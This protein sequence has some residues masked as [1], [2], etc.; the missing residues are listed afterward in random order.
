VPFGPGCYACSSEFA[1][2]AEADTIHGPAASTSGTRKCPDRALLL[3]NT[4]DQ[5]NT[6]VET[7][8]DSNKESSGEDGTPASMS[9]AQQQLGSG[10][11][12]AKRGLL[13]RALV[14]LLLWGLCVGLFG[15]LCDQFATYVDTL[16]VGF[17][18]S[19]VYLLECRKACESDWW[20]IGGTCVLWWPCKWAKSLLVLAFFLRW[21]LSRVANEFLQ[22]AV[23]LGSLEEADRNQAISSLAFFAAII[24]V[25]GAG[26]GTILYLF[27]KILV[28]LFHRALQ[29]RDSWYDWYYLRSKTPISIWPWRWAQWTRPIEVEVLES[30][31][32]HEGV[33][34][35]E[36]TERLMLEV[37]L[38]GKAS[39]L[40]VGAWPDGV[41][42]LEIITP[43][44]GDVPAT[45]TPLG[46]ATFF[47]EFGKQW[48]AITRHQMRDIAAAGEG[49]VFVVGKNG[50]IP[51]QDFPVVAGGQGSAEKHDFAIMEVTD[52]NFSAR[53]GV[54]A[55]N[56][57]KGFANR[58]VAQVYKWDGL[59]WNF[60]LAIAN[61]PAHC[62]LI[63]H[64][65]STANGTSGSPLFVM[66]RGKL[67]ILGIHIG[68]KMKPAENYA[69]NLAWFGIRRPDQWRS[70]L[71]TMKPE[72]DPRGRSEMEPEMEELLQRLIYLQE[73]YEDEL[74]E[75]TRERRLFEYEEHRDKK[76]EQQLEDA[77]YARGWGETKVPEKVFSPSPAGA[78]AVTTAVKVEVPKEKEEVSVSATMA[79]ATVKEPERP[80]KG[81]PVRPSEE[82]RKPLPEEPSE[83]EQISQENQLLRQQLKEKK[84]REENQRLKSQL[85]ESSASPKSNSAKVPVN[86][87]AV[88]KSVPSGE[89]SPM[90]EKAGAPVNTRV[91]SSKK[92]KQKM[93]KPTAS[94][95]NGDGQFVELQLN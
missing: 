1:V 48:L 51:L 35:K 81:L 39:K 3:E 83:M 79:N 60:T 5:E 49:S 82:L 93:K 27:C 57:V 36:E 73:L 87:S 59:Q 6:D 67:S 30:M 37:E 11:S 94:S 24:A 58:V 76:L 88:S 89:Q 12:V 43:K 62:G 4:R 7:P 23:F 65:C 46:L 50:R 55:G 92:R 26:V 22:I 31:P 20:K 64:F 21:V 91:S 13:S 18:A 28:S 34:T 16:E 72:S 17:H 63:T 78:G 29:L 32:A 95:E 70:Y 66:F 90:K 25:A 47:T 41:L 2:A 8:Q 56:L 19:G 75:E 38:G 52:R 84:L 33:L 69:V 42:R 54:K 14:G 10:P 15:Y 71:Q 77:A 80:R 68:G 9:L 44:M 85:K 61:V 86:K 45:S 53:L 74:N 40:A